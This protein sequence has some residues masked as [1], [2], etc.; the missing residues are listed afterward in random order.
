MAT[1]SQTPL[2]DST[3]VRETQTPVGKK[4]K[5]G[6]IEHILFG[7]ALILAVLLGAAIRFSPHTSF[8][9]IPGVYRA[10]SVY[11]I[12]HILNTGHEIRLS[13]D[14]D[15]TSYSSNIYLG[16]QDILRHKVDSAVL[17][18]LGLT[19]HDLADYY[20]YGLWSPLV[21]FPLAVM[22]LY[23][24]L[25]RE[26]GKASR[27]SE[28]LAII[29]FATLGSFNLVSVSYHGET[30]TSTGW[31]L[32]VIA[33]YGLL[34]IPEAPVSGRLTFFSF[35]TLLIF[36]YHT[37]AL[38]LAC[39]AA[40]LALMGMRRN[41]TQ[42][43]R[44]H[45]PVTM[46]IIILI[47][48]TYFMYVSVSFFALFATTLAETPSLFNFLV[49]QQSSDAPRDFALADLLSRG[50]ASFRVPLAI[51]AVLVSLPVI[52]VIVLGLMK[53]LKAISG[54]QSV[55]VIYPWLMGLM[56]FSAALLIWSGLSGLMWKAAEFGSLYAIIAI[57]VLFTADLPRPARMTTFL[58]A[59]TCVALSSYLFYYYERQGASHLT[60]AEQD[61]AEW[62]S[63]RA[64]PNEAVFTDLRM[65]APLIV[66]DHLAVVGINDYD[67]PEQV[68]SLLE[69]I[70]YGDDPS[71]AGAMMR[72]IYVPEV[73]TL[74][75][76]M[77]SHRAEDN[78]PG[79]K[80]YDYNFKSAPPGYMDKYLEAPGFNLIYDNGTVRIFE[81][82]EVE[83]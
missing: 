10:A 17:L 38:L 24:A 61:A 78:L 13:E 12:Q 57:M 80:G 77:F 63:H 19:T 9:P 66:N 32:L 56:P 67:S 50:E 75:Y 5:K 43:T 65:A 31:T 73:F 25:C 79:I 47:D 26:R 40:T 1:Y 7:I 46:L 39:S 83:E 42:A 45:S 16:T 33:L 55:N 37:P 28:M 35:S 4:T 81:I 6:T 36:L 52:T 54:N 41:R 82:T 51:L 62:L 70:Y 22:T 72:T 71:I 64:A 14:H 49:R 8:Y 30:N 21:V 18:L 34:R 3:T 11:D 29:F 23:H 48:I 74:R 44:S 69:A 53:R 59:L 76:A 15:V 58:L 68:R 27:R 20:R 2:A 60:Y